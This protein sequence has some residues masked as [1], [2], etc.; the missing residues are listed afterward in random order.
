MNRRSLLQSLPLSLLSA[1]LLRGASLESP[2]EAPPPE[3]H[4]GNGIAKSG[5]AR[6]FSIV[7]TKPEVEYAVE[8]GGTADPVNEEI[9]IQNLGAQAVENPRLTVNGLYDWYDVKSM[10][11]EILR[12]DETDKGKALAIW[13]WVQDKRWQRDLDDPS[14]LNPVRGLNGYG[15]CI[16]GHTASWMSALCRAAGLKTRVWE[17][18]GHT[19]MEA[20]FDGAWHMLDANAKTFYL[21]R[22]NRTIASIETLEHDPWLIERTIH[23]VLHSDPWFRGP[24]PA[25]TEMFRDFLVTWRDNWINDG[26]ESEFMKHYDMS[27]TLRPE[28]R[29]VRWWKP[30]RGRFYGRDKNP[31]VPM[32]YANGQLIWEPDLGRVDVRNY[33]DLSP[34]SNIATR[35]QDGH[36]PA[37]HIARIQDGVFYNRPARFGIPIRSP[38]PV[39]GGHVWCA[40][41]KEGSSRLDQIRMTF[42]GQDFLFDYGNRA[43]SRKAEVELDCS[44]IRHEPVY[45]GS[46]DFALRGNLNSKPPTQAGVEAFRVAAD[47][48][49]APLSLPALRLG[50]NIVRYWDNSPGSRRVRI[51][52]RWRE[53]T[54]HRPPGNGMV[55][56]APADDGEVATLEP[57]L[58][59][60]PPGPHG[61]PPADYQV[62]VS[63]ER[64]CRW[65]VSPTLYQNVGSARPEW[66]VP[67]T[68][69]NRA[70]TYYWKV[71]ARNREGDIGPWSRA[72][73]FTTSPK[74]K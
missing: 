13:T 25:L 68:F 7:I 74:S 33:L 32:K 52:H 46:V 43:G 5:V 66:K 73:A 42:D 48:Q 8:V 37:I 71:R 61:A 2:P 34:V 14:V 45:E 69:L 21:D 28:E 67:A 27:M 38:Y 63:P 56:V 62:M 60:T 1:K 11:K 49:V 19:V 31:E 72:F 17:L 3:V 20:Y 39:V 47:L 44:M 54:G 26:Y 15:Y 29:L 51:T 50:K 59:W 35:M 58:K 65:P 6:E 70:T 23:P 4:G 30:V 16:C 24:D 53:I 10:L 18:A 36:N 57:T 40:F 64:D 55:A 22:D 9:V 41:V 12:G